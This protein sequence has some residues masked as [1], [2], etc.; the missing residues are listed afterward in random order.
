MGPPY[1]EGAWSRVA[2]PMEGTLWLLPEALWRTVWPAA[3]NS[4]DNYP[5]GKQS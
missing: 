4:T 5:K 3:V 2:T 1:S